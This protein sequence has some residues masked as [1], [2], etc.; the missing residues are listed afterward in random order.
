MR[1]QKQL[2]MMIALGSCTAFVLFYF[3]EVL[4][5]LWWFVIFISITSLNRLVYIWSL[6]FAF[7]SIRPALI[8]ENIDAL[9]RADFP[10]PSDAE[11]QIGLIPWIYSIAQRTDVPRAASHLA[12]SM[13]SINHAYK[14]INFELASREHWRII[15]KT[16]LDYRIQRLRDANKNSTP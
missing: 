9:V 11:L 14:S 3:T 7:R 16:F 12:V 2:L 10:I 8:G 4:N 5:P 15:H 13:V 6:I 1:F